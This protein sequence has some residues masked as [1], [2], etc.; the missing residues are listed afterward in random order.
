MFLRVSTIILALCFI[1]CNENPSKFDG[2]WQCNDGSATIYTFKK[3]NNNSYIMQWD[4]DK[5]ITGLVTKNDVFETANE[6]IAIDSK[7]N[8][9]ILPKEWNCQKAVKLI[10]PEENTQDNIAETNVTSEKIASKSVN[11]TKYLNTKTDINKPT[12]K[13]NINYWITDET[14]VYDCLIRK[15][16]IKE[17][18]KLLTVDFI[19]LKKATADSQ[20][21][22]EIVNKNPK[23][24]TFAFTDKTT[25]LPSDLK[26]DTLKKYQTNNDEGQVFKI[27]VV[28]GK[29]QSL[30]KTL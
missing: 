24:R 26:F 27:S 4:N 11:S 13:T 7:T 30:T 29:I 15:Q 3:V 6:I 12:D 16:E 2:E 18:F 25:F 10:L 8:E 22:F 19:Q 5:Y 14:I 23:L 28:N 20:N 9:L 17:G 21:F 1:S